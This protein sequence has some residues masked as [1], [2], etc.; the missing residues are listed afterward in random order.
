MATEH[1]ADTRAIPR[2]ESGDVVEMILEDHRLFES[3][4]RDLRSEQSARDA[5][6]KQ[7]AELLVAH[8]EAE[9]ST[10]YV[11][12]ERKQA[13]DEKQAE[14]GTKEHDGDCGSLEQVRALLDAC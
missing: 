9:E 1:S 13:V 7:M 2:T 5:L 14:H 12:L 6:G 4:L 3:L 8:G 10:V 11:E